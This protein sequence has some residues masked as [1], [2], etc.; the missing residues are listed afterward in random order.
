MALR[1][2][3]NHEFENLK[4][5]LKDAT[6]VIKQEGKIAVISFHS[7]EDKIVKNYF[8]ELI[9]SKEFRAYNKKVIAPK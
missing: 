7:L 1:I 2:Y 6:S 9:S 5:A 8:K 4:K 3:V